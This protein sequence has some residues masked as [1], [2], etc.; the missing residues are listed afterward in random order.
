MTEFDP[1]SKSKKIAASWQQLLVNDSSVTKR[2][3]TLV[4]LG[5]NME[6][7]P[8]N[9]G[10]VK[11]DENKHLLSAVIPFCSM[12]DDLIE[13]VVRSLVPVCTRV[14]LVTLTHFFTG[15]PDPRAYE[16]AE[17]L[18][19]EYK[20]VVAVLVPWNAEQGKVHQA[21]W[22]CEMRMQGFANTQTPWVLMVDAD[23]VLRNAER[24]AEWFA[25][26]HATP[27]TPKL[28]NYWYFLSKRRRSK[29]L[30]DSIVLTHRS[31]V[32]FPMFR[33]FPAERAAFCVGESKRMV[34]GLDGEPMFDHYSWVRR[35]DTL[36]KKVVTWG[37]RQ[38]RNWPDLVDKA[39]QEDLLTTPD[40]LHGY[41]Y[42]ILPE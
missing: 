33:Q 13:D 24:F 31:L 11:V 10:R 29:T 28:A 41:T 14:V 19:R 15:E 27:S 20:E 1:L 38:D 26:Q 17:G 32:T 8:K 21:F 34:K 6:Q 25:T 16:I 18:S 36:R 30:E 40:F 42:E 7:S 9:M 37:H 12:E 2:C 4:S 35:P 3:K 39:L 5:R 23:E 22:P